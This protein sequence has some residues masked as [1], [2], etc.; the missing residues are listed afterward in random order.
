MTTI[1]ISPATEV[2]KA[3][4]LLMMRHGLQTALKMA[5]S[6]KLS[7]RRARSRRRFQF[8]TAIAAEIEASSRE[9]STQCATP[10]PLRAS[11]LVTTE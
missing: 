4:Q 6:E 11:Q 5:A 7:A 3:A 1:N 2:A 9:A 10:H 8:W